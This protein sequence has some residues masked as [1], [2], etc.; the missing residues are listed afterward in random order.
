VVQDSIL[1]PAGASSTSNAQA[2]VG[3]CVPFVFTSSTHGRQ[4]A[5]RP[6]PSS[7]TNARPIVREY[8]RDFVGLENLDL[9]TDQELRRALLDFSFF[10]AVGSMDDAF[11][12]VRKVF[13]SSTANAQTVGQTLWRNMAKMAVQTRK[14]DV[15]EMCIRRMGIPRTVQLDGLMS[16]A[17]FSVTDVPASD[18]SPE[19]VA[20]EKAAKLG[21]IAIDLGM[22]ETAERIYREADRYDLLVRLHVLVGRWDE[23]IAVA[24][25]RDRIHLK[26]VQYQY[27]RDLESQG[28]VERA[29]KLFES[30]QMQA[31]E[32]PRML[33][34]L[35]RMDDLR[36]YVDMY[37]NDRTSPEDAQARLGLMKWWA[38]YHESLGDFEQ[39]L[40]YYQLAGDLVSAVRVMCF[41]GRYDDAEKL[42]YSGHADA[43]KTASPIHGAAAYLLAR[44]LEEV[45][46]EDMSAGGDSLRQRAIRAYAAA[47][48]YR[49]ALRVACAAGLDGELMGL[50]MQGDKTTKREAAE[51]FEQQGQVDRAVQLYHKSGMLARAV[52][53]CIERHLYEVLDTIIQELLEATRAKSAPEGDASAQPTTTT[54]VSDADAVDPS[55][56]IRCAEFFASHSKYERASEL[57]AAGGQFEKALDVL[58]VRNVRL[59]D[60]VA[61]AMTARLDALQDSQRR[62][63]VL[64]QMAQLAMQQGNFHLATKKFTQAGDRVRAM[65]ALVQSGDVEKI[66]FFA[67]VSKQRELY[68]LAA[69]HLQNM[70][71]RNDA[72]IMKHIV[73]LYSKAKAPDALASFYEACAQIEIDDYRDYDR[74]LAALREA[75]K[76]LSKAR[77][78]SKERRAEDLQQRTQRVEKFVAARSAIAGGDAD[79]MVRMCYDLIDEM[80]ALE[81]SGG[82]AAMQSVAALRLGDV[83]ALLVEY[84]VSVSQTDKARDLLQQMRQLRIKLDYFLGPEMVEFLTQDGGRRAVDNSGGRSRGGQQARRMD[85]DEEPVDEIDDEESVTAQRHPQQ[86]RSNV[87][88]YADDDDD[89]VQEDQIIDEEVDDGDNWS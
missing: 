47:G 52:E 42:S 79:T 68:M 17:E 33:Y 53:M 25:E 23:A 13:S 85:D 32:V 71:W 87:R 64:S 5:D 45:A 15:A 1:A 40:P 24:R 39:A 20:K 80:R 38:G 31:T 34:G 50:A 74:A 70:D 77:V 22:F 44:H 67:N 4:I 81:T 36:I 84:F 48:Q 66:V 43:V 16:N 73:S 11:K 58:R 55:L 82:A 10:L 76:Y 30:A 51:Y 9:F 61:E 62:S 21:A 83:F 26:T 6:L 54:G 49:Q 7:A 29:I 56:W 12:A 19:D 37:K 28:Q 2:F 63:L 35:G 27:A 46:A 69:N 14:V 59:S 57:Y 75:E 3:I 86:P 60:D 65:Q 72:S 88:R 78:N 8:L 18:G 89:V 41:L